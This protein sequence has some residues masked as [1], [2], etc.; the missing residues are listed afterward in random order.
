M[1]SFGKIV[2]VC[3]G[4]AVVYDFSLGRAFVSYIMGMVGSSI[5]LGIILFAVMYFTVLPVARQQLQNLPAQSSLNAVHMPAAYNWLLQSPEGQFDKMAQYKGRVTVLNIW[6]TWCAPCRAEMPSL[7]RLSEQVQP[8]GIA[9]LGISNEKS[10]LVKKFLQG[11]SFLFPLYSHTGPLPPIFAS[12]ILPTTYVLSE[13]GYI[14]AMQQGATNW[15]DPA[16]IAYLKSL[17]GKRFA[18]G[19]LSMGKGP[20]ET[21]KLIISH[22]NWDHSRGDNAQ[23]VE[24]F[25]KGLDLLSR[26]P[27]P[28]TLMI[29]VAYNGLGNVG[30]SQGNYAEAVRYH[31]QAVTILRKTPGVKASDVVTALRNLEKDY[32]RLKNLADANRIEQQARMIENAGTNK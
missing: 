30:F 21:A 24:Y 14:V 20:A 25:R 11:K 15:D 26:E 22:A 9:V 13:D 32:Q 23:A 27:I 31:T 10:E 5:A 16:I 2:L 18:S 3:V 1:L 8:E 12:T 28:Q 17:K 6:A 19:E 29:G 4:I 7:Q